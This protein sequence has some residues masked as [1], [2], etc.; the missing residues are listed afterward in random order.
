MRELF[1]AKI[2]TIFFKSCDFKVISSD[3]DLFKQKNDKESI[4]TTN[5]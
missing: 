5:S 3:I 2:G 4:C 1:F